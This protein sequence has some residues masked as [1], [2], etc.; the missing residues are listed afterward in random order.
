MCINMPDNYTTVNVMPFFAATS[1]ILRNY[2]IT[3]PNNPGDPVCIL[4]IPNSNSLLVAFKGWEF[5]PTSEYNALPQHDNID[6][7]YDIIKP[8]GDP[9]QLIVDIYKL[10][11][12]MPHDDYTY[13]PVYLD[14]RLVE[15]PRSVKMTDE[16]MRQYNEMLAIVMTEAELLV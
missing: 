8:V 15:V 4:K 16:N 10:L 5:S 6:A 2:N 12:R 13:I 14:G 11:S 7:L 3:A 1:T 9:A